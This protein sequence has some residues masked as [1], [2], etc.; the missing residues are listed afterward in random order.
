MKVALIVLVFAGCAI[1]GTQRGRRPPPEPPECTPSGNVY[2]RVDISGVQ[3]VAAEAEDDVSGVV[4]VW[5][6]LVP[7]TGPQ[8]DRQRVRIALP[9]SIPPYDIDFDTTDFA[10]GNYNLIAEA[11]DFLDRCGSDTKPVRIRN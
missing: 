8:R 11:R 10:N 4:G 9:D 5:F 7:T 1:G 6:Y 3:Y 2:S